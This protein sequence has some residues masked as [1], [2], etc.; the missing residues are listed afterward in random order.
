M[1]REGT[2]GSSFEFRARFYQDD[3]LFDPVSV[4][5]SVRIYDAATGGTLIA[6]V[7]AARESTGV[8][9]ATWSIPEDQASATY[10]DE[11]TWQAEASLGTAVQRNQFS[12]VS[13]YTLYPV[14]NSQ[15]LEYR[16][17]A[18]ETA[19]NNIQTALNNV[20][21]KR[22][23]AA[24][25]AVLTAAINDVQENLDNHIEVGHS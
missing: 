15:A 4:S 10:Y 23:L 24:L 21:T 13:N 16:L 17:Q 20:P 22:Q 3:E 5:T 6:T 11:W 7:T 19:I 25:N 2:K 12:V 9:V 14:Q 18:I 8:W 1:A